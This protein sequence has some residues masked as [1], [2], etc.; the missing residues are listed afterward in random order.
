[1]G[2]L[3]HLI[4]HI[5]FSLTYSAY[6]YSVY[7]LVCD[8]IRYFAPQWNGTHWSKWN[9]GLSWGLS[10]EITCNTTVVLKGR[11][12]AYWGPGDDPLDSSMAVTILWLILLVFVAIFSIKEI[13]DLVY[14]RM[15][16]FKYLSSGENCLSLL[17]LITFPLISLHE[18][19]KNNE[20]KIKIYQYHVAAI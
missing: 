7:S 17:T 20:I 18:L 6:I 11:R 5:I 9:N 10:F 8:P 4:S 19:P 16:I 1:M 3:A 12:I 13:A 14:V 2:Y 15:N